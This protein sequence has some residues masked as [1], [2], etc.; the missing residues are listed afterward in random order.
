PILS[1]K[2]FWF[3][4]DIGRIF[5]T[6]KEVPLIMVDGLELH[7]PP[8]EDRPALA[9]EQGTNDSKT[10]VMIGEVNVT[11]T[12]MVVHPSNPTKQPLQFQIEKLQLNSNGAGQPLSYKAS[13]TNPK[14]KGQ[15]E[16]TGSFG[17]WNS[18]DPGSSAL[19]G[20][21]TFSHADLS[22]FTAIAGILESTGTFHGELSSVQ[23]KGEAR[24]PDFRLKRS[25]NPLSLR[26]QFE[27]EVDGT[28]GNTTLQPVQAQL[29]NS[30]FT[31]SGAVIRY[32]GDPRRTIDFKVKMTRGR[33]EDFLRLAM[34]GPAF[35]QGALQLDAKIQIPPLAGK[36]V[37][38]LNLNGAFD[39]KQGLFLKSAIQDKLDELSRKG[40]GD[41]SNEE[42]DE[43]VSHMSGAFTMSD[44][45]VQFSRLAFGVPGADIDLSGDYDM[46]E[47]ALDF[48]GSLRMIAKVSQTQT[49]V[50][51]WLLKP[52]DP[53][54][55]K[56]GAGT[57]LR[58]KIDGTR[59][60]PSFGL[61]HKK[62]EKT[63][64]KEIADKK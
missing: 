17:P 64:Q 54:F 36:V 6:P 44:Q 50:K 9:K 47:E 35:M 60:N 27:A 5:D 38:K 40:Q 29:G 48:H 55:S 32:K 16:S 3:Q 58:I 4:V 11:N 18:E 61:D 25:G 49:G 42:I 45:A 26:T 37:E 21:Y 28:N 57:L 56:D 12:L 46:A 51:R 1:M 41:P 59:A 23:V 30:Q 63:N 52:V 14:P 20:M 34:K 2:N 13:L 8:K 53:F 39:V 43:V 62:N 10:A 31:T 24:V 15:V 19:E 22:V 33:I 7:V